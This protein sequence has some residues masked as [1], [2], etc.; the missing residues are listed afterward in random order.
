MRKSNSSFDLQ[1]NFVKGQLGPVKEQDDEQGDLTIPFEPKED[2][3]EE[4][5][6]IETPKIS[7]QHKMNHETGGTLV[8]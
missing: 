3:V 6:T 8:Y 7:P 1:F 5:P 4:Q 2:E